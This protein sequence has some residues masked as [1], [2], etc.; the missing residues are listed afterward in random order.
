MKVIQRNKYMVGMIIMLVIGLALSTYAWFSL[1]RNVS[2][3]AANMTT[4]TYGDISIAAGKVTSGNFET[5]AAFDELLLAQYAK[6]DISSN[7]TSFLKWTGIKK[8]GTGEP[9][10]FVTAQP[11]TDYIVQDFTFLSSKSLDIYLADESSFSN[12]GNPAKD[13]SPAGRAAFYEWDGDSYNLMFVWAPNTVQPADS[14]DYVMNTLGDL[15]PDGY[16]A[17]KTGLP[18]VNDVNITGGTPGKVATLVSDGTNRV[19][20]IQVRVWLEGTD[21]ASDKANLEANEGQ[22]QAEFKFVASQSDATEPLSEAAG[23]VTKNSAITQPALYPGMIPV[24]YSD[25]KWL[26]SSTK[27]KEWYNYDN[28]QWGNAVFVTEA[29]RASYQAAAVDTEIDMGHVLGFLVWIPRYEYRINP[30]DGTSLPELYGS[31]ASKGTPG[32]IEINFISVAQTQPTTGYAINKAFRSGVAAENGWG[33]GGWTSELSGFWIGKFETTGTTSDPTIL[34]NQTSLRNQDLASQYQKALSFTG[35]SHS[36]G[37]TITRGSTAKYGLTS[38]ARLTKNSEWGAVA[39]LS[40]SIYGKYGNIDFR[41]ADKEI[42]V[43]PSGAYIT[44]RSG[45]TVNPALIT[46]T[47]NTESASLYGYDGSSCATK[48]SYTCTGTKSA[49]FG[50][51]ASTTGNIYGVY[52]MSGGSLESVMGNYNTVYASYPTGLNTAGTSGF[53]GSYY[54]PVQYIDYYYEDND[55]CGNHG[56]CYGHALFENIGW[57]GDATGFVNPSYP[58]LTRGGESGNTITAGI[59]NV[60]NNNGSA[61]ANKGWRLT[62]S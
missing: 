21:A 49:L 8:A 34:P 26:K 25:G 13:L 62:V 29:T 22:W 1:R 27:Y 10:N 16:T 36:S 12:P 35:D 32:A 55:T 59:F 60:V 57:Y 50:M 24:K 58:W 6:K 5:T 7:G 56:S 61:S 43:N 52:D 33:L 41:Y 45:S 48:T 9:T 37:L 39:L 2:L 11:Y 4:R 19:R 44:G 15:D 40:Q 42:F 3:T 47:S 28:Q 51:A 18:S 53:N 23:A 31:E 20:T 17:I 14:I 46:D 38:K 54:P 30:G